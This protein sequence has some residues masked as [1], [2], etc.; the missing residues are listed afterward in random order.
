MPFL[1]FY[2]NLEKL[3][4]EWLQVFFLPVL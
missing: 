1:P 4:Y 3:K 2:I